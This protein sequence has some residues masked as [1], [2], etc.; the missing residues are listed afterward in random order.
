MTTIVEKTMKKQRIK[1]TNKE[2]R[3][4][5]TWVFVLAIFA[6]VLL[7]GSVGFA[8]AGPYIMTLPVYETLTATYTTE[9][10]TNESSLDTDNTFTLTKKNKYEMNEKIVF[11][12]EDSNVYIGPDPEF[13]YIFGNKG[14]ENSN[15]SFSFT[16]DTEKEYKDIV[17]TV[18]SCLEDGSGVAEF[19]KDSIIY[20]EDK[21][22]K[23]E[24]TSDIFIKKVSV[25]YKLRVKN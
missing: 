16:L 17:L 6:I 8:I 23:I 19:D 12:S 10:L 3:N 4:G 22:I 5:R 15:V 7:L 24:K 14:A 25:T 21:T 9:M 20:N 1:S 13:P 11:S 18:F 2:E